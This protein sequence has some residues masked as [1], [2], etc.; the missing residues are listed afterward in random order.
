[1]VGS[2]AAFCNLL[3]SWA[4]SD[5][6]MELIMNSFSWVES[7][8]TVKMKLLW[9]EK[10]KSTLR[11]KVWRNNSFLFFLLMFYQ[12]ITESPL[13]RL[14]LIGL[15]FSLLIF[16]A[17]FFFFKG[18]TIRMKKE[19]FDFHSAVDECFIRL[20]SHYYYLLPFLQGAF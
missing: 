9:C 5:H 11:S 3:E 6:V 12:L 8:G 2:C 15:I 14:V 1:M 13:G 17:D 7:L 20:Y 16:K 10:E 4:V 18:D 19:G